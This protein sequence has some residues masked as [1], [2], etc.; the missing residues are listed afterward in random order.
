MGSKQTWVEY[1]KSMTSATGI[2]GQIRRSSK[3]Q[4]VAISEQTRE[5]V[6]SREALVKKFSS[7]FD[8][9]N[10]TLEW[11]FGRM[12]NAMNGVAASIDALRASF[13]YNMTLVLEQLQLQN[14][15]MTR[16]LEQM[17]AI[18]DTLQ[19]P[20]LTQARE[21]YRI[22]CERLSKGLLDKALEA[23]LE[24]VRRNDTNFM[25]HLMIGKLY[26]YGVSNEINVLN[27]KK[28]EFHLRAAARYAKA[29][30]TRLPDANRFAGEALLHAAISCYVQADD[31][32][33]A[34]NIPET[35]RLLQ[36]S[37]DLARQAAEVYPQL[38]ESHYHHAKFAS[39][40]G[41]GRTAKASLA[42]AIAL[43]ET[44]CLK[45][46]IDSDFTFVR[47]QVTDLFQQL[48]TKSGDKIRDKLR[49]TE[50]L[51]TDW[52]YLTSEA[53]NAESEI[54]LMISEA[55]NCL[56]RN[57]YFDN[58]DALRLLQQ[59]EQIFQTLLVHKFALHA[60]S[61]N[62]GR[63]TSI[64]FSPNQKLLASG[65]GEK[66]VKL[67]GLSENQLKATLKGHEDTIVE[68]AFSHDSTML[69]S[70]D[71][72]G[73]VK[74]WD[75]E[76]GAL[77]RDL[78][79]TMS[80][81]HCIAFSPD[82]TMLA[83][84]CD[85]REAT[86]WRVRT[87][88]LMYT[89]RAH[90]SSVDTVVFSHDSKMMATGSPDNTAVVWD[91]NSGK[92]LQTFNGCSGLANCLAFSS[93]DN[94]LVSGCNDGSVRFYR[95]QDGELVH[96]IS[97]R[98]G[99]VS[100]IVLSPDS[101]VLATVNVGKALQL[102]DV[103]SGQLLHNLKPFSR[104]ITS[105]RFSPD[106]TILSALDFQDRSVKLWSVNDG[107]LM[108]VIA[109]NL[110]CSAFSPD[111]SMLVTGDE[112]GSLRFWGRMVTTRG[113]YEE[114]RAREA[115]VAEAK[116]P[117]RRYEAR[118]GDGNLRAELEERRRAEIL[119]QQQERRETPAQGPRYTEQR[120]REAPA[121]SPRFTEQRP[122]ETPPES[123]RFTPRETPPENPRFAE[124]RP[125]ETPPESPRYAEQRPRETPPQSPRLV[126]QRP[127]DTSPQTPRFDEGKPRDN[128]DATQYGDPEQRVRNEQEEGEQL[129][130][131]LERSGEREYDQDPRW[132]K[133]D[134]EG[135]ES[136]EVLL[137]EEEL[138]LWREQQ[139]RQLVKRAKSGSCLECGRKLGLLARISG[140]KFCRKHAF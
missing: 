2:K 115:A 6:A 56:A 113:A 34:G 29:E 25:T 130:R 75:A 32:V 99:T 9:V 22:G 121:Q 59:A 26:L 112:T 39:L 137:H 116:Q 20:T 18:H 93:D 14:Q 27:V 97:E 82:D 111:G 120:P 131:R 129:R 86:L 103:A 83:I 107:K 28:A 51:L 10:G 60:L 123:P 95:I 31:Q 80:P 19:S 90:K 100:W 117:H 76:R 89:F 98:S 62:F 65:G 139:Q 35:Q 94:V 102:W 15:T 12:E 40:L 91:A 8:S 44:Y 124:Q 41:D 101:K 36:A 50:K 105:A 43:D 4:Q 33:T 132:E 109:G 84:G 38:S 46:D 61:A 88:S 64:A 58:H 49:S 55:K 87:G 108:H 78:V 104:G 96:S 77:L 133:A 114:S 16:F 21:F 13:D 52:V 126:D 81:V 70:V 5:I 122:R 47:A 72:R 74:I 63:I 127:R 53:K 23:F 1:L 11:G 54:R 85:N 136:K 30:I 135:P 125:R 110:T 45:A 71:K 42:R 92:L 79:D 134:R 37:L 140:V 24:A 7:G 66:V 119:R 106:G 68:L 69:A 3:E 118:Q 138:R 17:E 128:Y 48:R 67:W 57:T 73:S